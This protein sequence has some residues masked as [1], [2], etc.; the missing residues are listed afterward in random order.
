MCFRTL[1]GSVRII[2]QAGL[3]FVCIP[4]EPKITLGIV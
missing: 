4:E 2:A 1:L 3:W